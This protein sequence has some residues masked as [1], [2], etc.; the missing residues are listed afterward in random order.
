MDNRQ[1]MTKC[2]IELAHQMIYASLDYAAQ[3]GFEP[4][5]DWTQSQYLLQPRGEL[6]EPYELPCG[7]DHQAIRQDCWSRQ[8]PCCDQPV[9]TDGLLF[10]H[11]DE[12]EELLI[13]TCVHN[14]N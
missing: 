13:P 6:E 5:S 9:L 8:L 2:P 11:H 1:K 4:Q 7:T 10:W 3:F 14:D 12:G